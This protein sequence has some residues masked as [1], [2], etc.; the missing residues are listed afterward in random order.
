MGGS[1]GPLGASLRPLGGLFGASWGALWASWEPLRPRA[2]WVS[3]LGTLLEPFGGPL[4]PSWRPL[5]PFWGPLASLW[6]S[7]GGLLGYLG[8]ILG[9]YWAVL[10]CR[11]AEKAR[12]PKSFKNNWKINDF[13]LLVPS[14]ECSW[15]PLGPSWK[16]LGPSGGYFSVLD[17]SFGD[18][19]PSWTV[20]GA[21]WG[22]LGP[23]WSFSGPRN[24][25]GGMRIWVATPPR[26]RLRVESG[27]WVGNLRR[28]PI[29]FLH[30]RFGIQ[31]E[32]WEDNGHHHHKK[33]DA[34]KGGGPRT[35]PLNDGG[36]PTE[37]R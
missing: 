14:W 24:R 2:R 35:G 16:L 36:G 12:T 30:W 7:L 10:E 21:S 23:S 37:G 29:F 19:G 22:T 17:R 20:L 8:A 13:C 3:R 27:G 18:S 15:R 9:A 4:G 34:A 33:Q 1:W 11:E 32:W 6:G 5:G 25:P 28:L 31:K 26:D